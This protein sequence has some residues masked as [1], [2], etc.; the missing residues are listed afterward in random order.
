[1]NINYFESFVEIAKR[2]SFS[3]AAKALNFSQPALSFHIQALEKI[4]G[5]T[6][7]DRSGNKIRLT[8]AGKAFLPYAKEIVRTNNRLVESLNE[9]KGKV[10]GRLALG[11]STIPGEYILPK[12]LGK[13]IAFFP[14]VEPS[15]EIADTGIVIDKI[16]RHEIDL[17]FVGAHPPETNLQ[18]VPF[19]ED[20]LVLVCPTSH[21]LAKK[22]SVTVKQVQ[23]EPFILREEGS[24]TRTTFE[25]AL[26]KKTFSIKDLNIVMEL[27]STQAIMTAVESGLGV[28]VVSKWAIE[29]EIA[30]NRLAALT[31]EDLDLS[32]HLFLAFNKER[33]LTRV[34]KEFIDFVTKAT[35]P[36]RT[37]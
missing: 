16:K 9:L 22:T 5:E 6:L 10:R 27:G 4:Y 8:E 35:P 31:I 26:R 15:M 11:A 34:Q 21:R 19:A 18:T 36:E 24:G 20:D 12:L 23:K 13:F 3:E 25:K 2:G 33:P 29:K 28:S 32:R 7:F 14:E 17:G 1:M 37:K 30:L